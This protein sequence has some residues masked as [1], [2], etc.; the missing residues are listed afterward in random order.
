MK[1]RLVLVHVSSVP[2]TP[3]C[4]RT[5]LASVLSLSSAQSPFVS[6]ELASAGE[7]RFYRI[8]RRVSLPVSVHSGRGTLEGG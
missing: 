1:I 4:H 7:A 2:A 5:S 6:A 8:M 3:K